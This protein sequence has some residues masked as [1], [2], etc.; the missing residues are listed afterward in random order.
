MPTDFI[1]PELGEQITSGDVLRILVKPGD[2]LVKDQPVLE[3]ETDKATIEVPSSVAGEVAEIKVKAGDTVKVGQAILSVVDAGSP[4][5]STPAAAPSLPKSATPATAAEPAAPAAP[6]SSGE[7]ANAG[8]AGPDRSRDNSPDDNSTDDSPEDHAFE[9]PVVE[10][11]NVSV[12]SDKPG[13]KEQRGRKVV[14]ITRGPRTTPETPAPPDSSR[15][16]RRRRRFAGWPANWASTS[17][18][19]PGAARPG[20][21][22]L[23]T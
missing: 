23:M 14:D 7:N 2:V 21:F 3:L 15:R 9:Q 19:S 8:H 22:R 11:K 10:M 17:T 1:L 6:V 16:R 12:E 13:V 18:M 5:A 4:K 20:V